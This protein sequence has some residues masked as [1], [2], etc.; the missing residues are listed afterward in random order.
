ME[1]EYFGIFSGKKIL[2]GITGGIAAYKMPDF[3]RQMIKQGAEVRVVMTE[4]AEKFVTRLTMETITGHECMVDMF[5][6]K[7]FYATH[8]IDW[9]DWADAVLIAPATANTIAKLAVGMADNLLTT[10]VLASTAP[11]VIAPAMNVHMWEN[12]LVQEN[13]RKLEHSGYIICPPESGFLACGYTGSGRLAPYHHIQQ[14]LLYALQKK[15]NL[16]GKKVLITLGPTREFLDPVRFLSN[17]SSGKMGLALALEAFAR[18]AEV[19]VI[20]GPVQLDIPVKMEWIPVISA[21]E[22]AE[23]VLARFPNSDIFISAAAVAD[24]KPV[25]TSGDKIKKEKKKME[26]SLENTIDILQECGKVKT[27]Q[28]VIGFALESQDLI[29]NGMEKMRNKNL[30]GI[31]INSTRQANGGMGKDNNQA[32][33]FDSRGRKQETG[34]ILKN[35]L[36]KIIFDFFFD[37]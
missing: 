7:G 25:S 2:V 18:G 21:A 28:T 26:L 37:E 19:T 33:L 29:R 34:L 24:Y 12:P 22:M 36:A 20:A 23:Q 14:F 3:I 11:K 30:D 1:N 16:K 31:V 27:H 5:P 10:I 8:H 35:E 4:A 9:A 15:K 17:Y 32:I 6:D 13:L